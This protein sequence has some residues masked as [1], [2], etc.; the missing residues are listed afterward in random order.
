M[1]I[2]PLAP[3]IQSKLIICLCSFK[4]NMLR[5]IDSTTKDSTRFTF[6]TSAMHFQK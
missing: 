2:K 3:K 4:W 1:T 5:K 6:K